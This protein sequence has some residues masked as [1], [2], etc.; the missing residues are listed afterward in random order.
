MI[1]TG[2]GIGVS[3]FRLQATGFTPASI[4]GLQ[5]WLDAD[6]SSTLYT[7]STLATLAVSD[8]DVIGGWKDKSGNNRH[9]LQSDGLKKPA[10]KLAVKN[11]KNG[12]YFLQAAQQF[13]QFSARIIDL[14][15]LFFVVRK[16]A[17]T[18]KSFICRDNIATDKDGINFNDSSASGSMQIQKGNLGNGSAVT[19]PTVSTNQYY[20]ISAKADGTN[21]SLRASD[22]LVATAANPDKIIVG[23]LA[24]Y[25]FAPP[26]YCLKGHMLEVIFYTSNLSAGD[27]S[28]VRSYLNAKWAVTP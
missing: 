4:S 21:R 1:G 9:A 24:N 11:G 17:V 15:D 8:G 25:H 10:L 5:L 28:M 26:Q 27:I 19:G 6:D 12:I 22:S 14:T 16:D 7:D 13:L 23:E 18:D 20:V 2:I 3:E